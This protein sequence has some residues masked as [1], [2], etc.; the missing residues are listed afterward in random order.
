MRRFIYKNGTRFDVMC[1]EMEMN[2]MFSSYRKRFKARAVGDGKSQ[3]H[4]HQ[5]R[6]ERHK[7]F[8]RQEFIELHWEKYRGR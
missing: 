6:S 3:M 5:P 2:R 4:T 1:S 7:L 8:V